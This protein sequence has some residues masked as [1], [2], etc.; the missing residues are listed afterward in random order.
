MGR[1]IAVVAVSVMMGPLGTGGCFL[2]HGRPSSDS[3]PAGDPDG[4][5]RPGDGGSPFADRFVGRWA[6]FDA[7]L[8]AV[9]AASVYEFAP[10]GTVALLEIWALPAGGVSRVETG[11]SCEFS[12]RWWA[13]DDSSLWLTS[14]CTD[15]VMRD[16][17]LRFLTDR[18]TDGEGATVDVVTVGGETEWGPLA[19][20]LRWT[21][22]RCDRADPDAWFTLPCLS[23]E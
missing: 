7:E 16:V 5:P 3:G 11:R 14:A 21:W 1:C 10:E 13:T 19:G 23:A 20:V 17:Q 4:S 12:D 15:G 22:A 6:V 9:S 8:R 18:T 2:S